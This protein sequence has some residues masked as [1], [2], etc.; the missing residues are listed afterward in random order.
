MKVTSQTLERRA[1]KVTVPDG[2]STITDRIRYLISVMRRT[3]AQF[4]KLCGIDPAGLSKMLSGRLAVSRRSISRITSASGVSREWLETGQGL[5][6]PRITD[7][8]EVTMVNAGTGLDAV[9]DPELCHFNIIGAPVYDVD[10]TAG[11]QELA[12]MFTSEHIVGSLYLPQ[13]DPRN[14][15]VR[16]SG[17]SMIP[18][19]PNGSFISI[20]RIETD[21][22]IYWGRIYLVVT[23]DYRMVKVL[24]RHDD[25]EFV[26]LHSLNPDYDDIEINRRDIRHLFLV[27]A[28]MNYD[29][30]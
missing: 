4:A 3:Q 16:V 13:I 22:T 24:H 15:I 30:L 25:P 17:D 8:P 6:Y 18:R 28:V 20:R 26:I 9:T 10:V 19:I 12:A 23:Q 21:A 14:P 7:A 1:S 29:V 27:E 2:E 11:R 5:P